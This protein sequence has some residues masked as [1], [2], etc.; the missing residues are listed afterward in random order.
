MWHL[1]PICH[2]KYLG[3]PS[4]SECRDLYKDLVSKV[5]NEC[6]NSPVFCIEDGNPNHFFPYHMIYLRAQNN[7]GGGKAYKLAQ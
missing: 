1:I 4:G 2:Q 5:T 7:L 3:P 6:A